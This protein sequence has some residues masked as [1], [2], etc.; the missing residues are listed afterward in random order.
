[1]IPIEE[2]IEKFVF[3]IPVEVGIA[4]SYFTIGAFS[5]DETISKKLLYLTHKVVYLFIK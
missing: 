4:N 2:H 1:M 3:S 5:S